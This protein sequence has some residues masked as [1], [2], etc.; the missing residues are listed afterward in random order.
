MRQRTLIVCLACFIAISGLAGCETF[1]W[2]MFRRDGQPSPTPAPSTGTPSA[3]SLVEYLNDNSRR[4]KSLRCTDV[5]ITASQGFKSYGLRAK[6]MTMKPRNFLMTA[7]ALGSPVVDIGS[8]ENEFWFWFSKS[9]EPF[10]FF[11]TYKDYEE[12]RAA[13]LPFPFQPE[14]IMDALGMGNY[15]PADKYQMESDANTLRLV[16]RTRSPQGQAVRKVIVFN[17]RPVLPP[18]PQV[19]AFLLIDDTTNKDI[20]AAHVIDVQVDAATGALVP[21]RF[22]LRW[23]DQNARLNMTF[24]GLTV[25]PHLDVAS[26]QRQPLQGVQSVDLG[27]GPGL[28]RAQ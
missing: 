27:R 6:M 5:D 19:Q 15:G 25:N 14:W 20:C 16:E 12:G 10:Q 26:F 1:R 24:N 22:E 7:S 4:I 18:T 3:A 8:N 9:P 2:G 11:C 28:S 17:R 21:R 13:R 23:P